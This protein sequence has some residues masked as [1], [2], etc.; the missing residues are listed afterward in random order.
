MKYRLSFYYSNK[1]V[2]GQREDNAYLSFVFS[3]INSALS[4]VRLLVEDGNQIIDGIEIK[5][6]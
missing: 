3:S 1:I 4:F 6:I 5:S 2:A